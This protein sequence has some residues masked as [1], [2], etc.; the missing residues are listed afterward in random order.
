[1]KNLKLVITFILLFST[2]K[3]IAQTKG[4]FNLNTKVGMAIFEKLNSTKN[5]DPN[6]IYS[7]NAGINLCA[8]A[9]FY[10]LTGNEIDISIGGAYEYSKFSRTQRDLNSGTQN[11]PINE[12]AN[13]FQTHS[14][15]L[16]LK[17]HYNLNNKINFS[18]GLIG[19]WHFSTILDITT[20]SITNGEK[21]NINTLTYYE[22]LDESYTYYSGGNHWFNERGANRSLKLSSKSNLQITFGSHF[23]LNSN[24]VLDVEFRKYLEEN[25][26]VYKSHNSDSTYL[27]FSSTVSVGMSYNINP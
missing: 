20:S 26:L 18:V 10:Y 15:L 24:L 8:G 23:K 17:L 27:P 12:R 19:T 22:G 14:I 21:S 2:L 6:H 9:S 1:M 7:A 25:K 3:N 5:S 13:Q 4:I 16:P 11:S